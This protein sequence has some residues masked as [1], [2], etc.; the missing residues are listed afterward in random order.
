MAEKTKKTLFDH[1][2]EIT[3][4][5]SK[6]YWET[7]SEEDKKTWSNYMILRFLSMK[8][9]WVTTLSEFQSHLQNLPPKML[10]KFLIEILPKKKE[11][12]KY[13]KGKSEDKYPKWIIEAV[14]KY[15][16]CSLRQSEDYVNILYS[17]E[18]GQKELLKILEAFGTD[19]KE[20]KKLKLKV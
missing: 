11:Y 1:V 18:G 7:L 15:N 9:D 5:Q 12:L 13:I 20:I 10:Y 17:I 4:V 6:N 19:P 14:A 3:S 8:Y 16:N 2:N